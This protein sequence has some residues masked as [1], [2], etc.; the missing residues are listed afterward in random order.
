M[1]K[2]S[3]K[4]WK[5]ADWGQRNDY[6]KIEGIKKKGMEENITP[7]SDFQ[8]CIWGSKLIDENKE[9]HTQYDDGSLSQCKGTKNK[10]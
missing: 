7:L 8:S 1:I 2:T 4:G 10:N 3:Q 6:I 9:F 5:K